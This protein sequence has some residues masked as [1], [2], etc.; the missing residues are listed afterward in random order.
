MEEEIKNLNEYNDCIREMCQDGKDYEYFFRGENNDKKN[1]KNMPSVFCKD[2]LLKDEHILIKKAISHFPEIYNGSISTF[3]KL[4]RMRHYELPVRLLDIT[5]SPL[6]SLY[7]ACT[8]CNGIKFKNEKDKDG[9]VYV[10]KEK[11]HTK[12]RG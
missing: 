3:Q 8:E 11:K 10:F 2:S 4:V 12:Y 6:V 7:F 1:I 9:F 5:S